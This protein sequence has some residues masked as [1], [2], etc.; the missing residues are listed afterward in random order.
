ME[1]FECRQGPWLLLRECEEG[2]KRLSYP[3]SH[4]SW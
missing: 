1:V 4:H 2:S 3:W